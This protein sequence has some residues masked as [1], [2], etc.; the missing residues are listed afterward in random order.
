MVSTRFKRGK[1]GG[2]SCNKYRSRTENGQGESDC[3]IKTD[4]GVDAT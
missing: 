1:I 2:E 4:P 3:L